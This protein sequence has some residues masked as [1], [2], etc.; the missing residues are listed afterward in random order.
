MHEIIFYNGFNLL[1]DLILAGIVG[2]IAYHFGRADGYNAGAN[3]AMDM[4]E[5]RGEYYLEQ[6]RESKH[7]QV[8]GSG[9]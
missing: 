1:V 7:E 2:S 6:Y 5:A 4:V 3:A 8:Q 9:S